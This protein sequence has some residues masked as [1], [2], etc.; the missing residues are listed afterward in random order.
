MILL[1]ME[2]G[3]RARILF[4]EVFIRATNLLCLCVFE[5][6]TSVKGAR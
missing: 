2:D 6:N 5:E 4:L 3:A 1:Y